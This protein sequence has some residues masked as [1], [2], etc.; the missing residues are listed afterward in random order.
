MNRT[1]MLALS[2]LLT[3]CVEV[4][5]DKAPAHSGDTG[6]YGGGDTGLEDD[7]DTS[8]HRDSESGEDTAGETGVDTVD[9]TDT[10]GGVVDSDTSLDSTPDSAD[11]S[12]DDTSAGTDTASPLYVDLSTA[13]DAKLIGESA[14]DAWGP[15]IAVAGGGDVNGDGRADLLVGMVGTGGPG[16][17]CSGSTYLVHG[18][19]SGELDLSDAD[20]ELEG[21]D[22]EY[23]AYSVDLAGDVN[24]DGYADI[25]IGAPY[26]S[27]PTED[28]KAGQAYVVLGPV[29]GEVALTDADAYLH[30]ELDGTYPDYSATG[31]GV[32]IAGDTNGDGDADM[33][34]GADD[35]DAGVVYLVLGPVSG[36][37]DLSDADLRVSTVTGSLGYAVSPAGDTNGDGLD[38]ILMSQPVNKD[39]SVLLFT[40]PASGDTTTADADA[41]FAASDDYLAGGLGAP[42]GDL[43]ADGYD[44]V[45]MGIPTADDTGAY[46]GAAW[47]YLGPFSGDVALTDAQAKLLGAMAYGSAGLALDGA[48]DVDGDGY[49]DF[50]VSAPEAFLAGPGTTWLFYGLVSGTLSLDEAD[51]QIVGE[52]DDQAGWAIAGAGDV[53]A[54]GLDDLLIGGPGDDDGG[55]GAGAAWLV[56]ASSL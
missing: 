16:E 50:A 12:A 56:L 31:C 52:G 7:S 2:W 17:D 38:D 5:P 15:R 49:A 25:L 1:S 26:Y 43:N 11:D 13:A 54:D 4:D 55:E 37:F 29:T 27:D 40:G 34:I 22:T 45:L 47:L 23:S 44:D 9:T 18:P 28:G 36:I 14:N 41:S 10:S 24:G 19:V 8:G 39:A 42:A 33:L 48:G 21:S 30:G 51:V 53:D 35:Y 6:V 32:A 46:A 3:G 20:A